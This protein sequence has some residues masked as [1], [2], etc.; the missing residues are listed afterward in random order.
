VTRRVWLRAAALG[1]I[2][3]GIIAGLTVYFSSASV[4]P[5]GVSGVPTWHPP[6]DGQSQRFAVVFPDRAACFFTVDD[7]HQLVA[8]LRLDDARDISTVAPNGDRVALRAASGTYTL[9]L[10][11]GKLARGGLA[12]ID[13]GTLT[14]VDPQQ[15]VMYVTQPGLLG[16]RVIDMRTGATVYVVHFKGFTWNP[17]FGPNPPS[18]GLSLAPDRPEL[19]VLDAPNH[20]LHAFD[21]SAVPSAPPRRIGDVRLE[22]TLTG[23][24]SLTRTADGRYLYVG[25]AGDVIDSQTQKS[26]ANLPAL[27]QANAVLEVDWV[28]GR[29]VF[30]GFPR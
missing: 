11:T 20:A 29:P 6:T 13:T 17:R 26:I 25:N 3:V 21:V 9:D 28:D 15:R 2:V 27:Q 14:A 8:Q 19:W 12:P 18:H 30:P 10:R 16:F 23:P 5:C 1:L 7:K 22:R 4:P 24:G